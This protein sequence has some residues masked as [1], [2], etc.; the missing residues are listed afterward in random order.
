MSTLQNFA[1][2][3]GGAIRTLASVE[4]HVPRVAGALRDENAEPDHDGRDS[5]SLHLVAARLPRRS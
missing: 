3:G 1:N 4:S 5:Q 2:R